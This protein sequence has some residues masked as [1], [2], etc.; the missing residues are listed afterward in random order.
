MTC[1]SG[2]LAAEGALLLAGAGHA[3]AAFGAQSKASETYAHLYRP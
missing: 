1:R 3:R 2:F